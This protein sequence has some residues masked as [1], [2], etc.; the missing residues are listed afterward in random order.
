MVREKVL[1]ETGHIS[2]MPA[3]GDAE[4]GG[5]LEF[6]ALETYYQ[7]STVRPR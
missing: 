7:G 4:T 5:L 6:P 1:K 3:H 2:I